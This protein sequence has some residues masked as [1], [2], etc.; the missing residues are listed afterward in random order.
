MAGSGAVLALLSATLYFP[1]VSASWSAQGDVDSGAI[2]RISI[3]LH[4]F[5]LVASG[6]CIVLSGVRNA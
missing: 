2:V 6:G 4:V 1:H 5:A 3:T